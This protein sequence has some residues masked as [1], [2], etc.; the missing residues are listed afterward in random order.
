MFLTKREIAERKAKR[1]AILK[2]KETILEKTKLHR[3]SPTK[4]GNEELKTF[5]TRSK[6][7][8]DELQK[9]DAELQAA[10]IERETK[11]IQIKENKGGKK[12]MTL[13]I[14]NMT[15]KEALASEIYRDAF[16]KKL[17]REAR[18]TIKRDDPE[19]TEPEDEILEHVTFLNAGSVESGAGYLLPTSS[20]NKIQSILTESGVVWN[21]LPKMNLK[22]NVTI[23][24][25][26]R[27]G[28]TANEYG[29]AELKYEFTQLKIEQTAIV[30][31][32]KVQNLLLANAIEDLE[33]YFVRESAK[34][35]KEQL[36]FKCLNGDGD[37]FDSLLEAVE[38]ETYAAT[39]VTYADV[40][41][42]EGS[43][44]QAY[45][46]GALWLMSRKTY[47]N[48]FKTMTDP[49]GNLLAST[50]AF[51]N[52]NAASTAHLLDGIRVEFSDDIPDGEFML[53]N[54]T[55]FI[56]NVS[57]NITIDV[58]TSIYQNKDQTA[59]YAKV[60]AGAKLLFPEEV[61]KYYKKAKGGQA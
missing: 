43:M 56:A 4:E 32:I 36:D 6:E 38:A 13:D 49:N 47:F 16:Y 52:G 42:C 53:F 7:L 55:Y 40:M 2:E 51:T 41:E 39:G 23:P 58:N 30:A 48:N 28:T 25:G 12:D 17:F 15:L 46:A 31:E 3:E 1:E 22:G 35:L 57:K 29:V 21:L 24:I 45:A 59:W 19:P 44:K 20:V 8:A 10:E 9:I 5:I 26:A 33:D 11:N 54:P 61:I 37:Y 60:Y 18:K 27:T 50:I 14:K 34:H